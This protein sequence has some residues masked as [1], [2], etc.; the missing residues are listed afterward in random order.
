MRGDI[1]PSLLRRPWSAHS[2]PVWAAAFSPDGLRVVTASADNTAR[3]WNVPPRSPESLLRTAREL[4][5]EERR[6]YLREE[7][8]LPSL[9]GV[10]AA[11]P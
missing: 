2:G 3:I 11:A 9:G 5:P 1:V 6:E 10:T 7:I 8:E 4:T